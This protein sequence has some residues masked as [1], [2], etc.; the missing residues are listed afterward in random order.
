[1]FGNLLMIDSI[2]QWGFVLVIALIIFG[3]KKM[4]E[5]G[6]QIGTFL[7]DMNKV[8]ND[9][10]GQI[11]S[12]IDNVSD[13]VSYSE[14]TPSYR[15]TYPQITSASAT[16]TMD[17]MTDYTIVGVTP[18]EQNEEKSKEEYQPAYPGYS[19]D[20]PAK[21]PA[22]E[23]LAQTMDPEPE[24]TETEIKGENHV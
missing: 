2:G 17:D 11:H 20:D 15:T 7:R 1:M 24:K 3:P 10:L 4:P 8:K 16:D 22:V 13:T 23:P 5:L 9:L 12:E 21:S 18:K 6:R 14:P 19:P